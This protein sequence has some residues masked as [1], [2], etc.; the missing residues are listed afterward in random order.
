MLRFRSVMTL[1]KFSSVHAQVHNHFSHGCHLISRQVYKQP[2]SAG[3]APLSM[4]MVAARAG[5][6][7]SPDGR[8]W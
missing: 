5:L 3:D 6:S 4:K 8:S 1:Q 2:T 7:E